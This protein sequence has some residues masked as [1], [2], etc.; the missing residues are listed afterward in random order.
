MEG[1]WLASTSIHSHNVCFTRPFSLFLRRLSGAESHWANT[2]QTLLANNLDIPTMTV[3]PK[4]A[5]KKSKKNTAPVSGFAITFDICTSCSLR[6]RHFFFLDISWGHASRICLSPIC[7][8]R[9][10]EAVSNSM[11]AFANKKL[12]ECWPTWRARLRQ[13]TAPVRPKTRRDTGRLA[14]TVFVRES[15]KNKYNNPPSA[16][17][18]TV[19]TPKRKTKL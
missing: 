16:P 2:P 10:V 11:R 3:N 15:S 19:R 8:D 6:F 18:E 9:V 4:A 12:V 7:G 14:V 13:L 5:V 1:F 17:G